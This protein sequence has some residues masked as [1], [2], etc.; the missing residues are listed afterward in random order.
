[1]VAVHRSPAAFERPGQHDE[2]V[3][4]RQVEEPPSRRPRPLA[5]QLIREQT[6]RTL[7]KAV[8]VRLSNPDGGPVSEL[9][10]VALCNRQLQLAVESVCF[11]SAKLDTSRSESGFTEQ[12]SKAPTASCARPSLDSSPTQL[13]G[14]S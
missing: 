11:R 5:A 10:E 6:R 8:V 12:L 2:T 9:D 4:L 3:Q 1:V 7:E 13:K 14:V